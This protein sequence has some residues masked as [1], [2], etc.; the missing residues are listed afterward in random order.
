MRSQDRRLLAGEVTRRLVGAFFETYNEIGFG[1]SEA[2]CA[3]SLAIVLEDHGIEFQ[4]EPRIDVSF[5]G[6]R[7]GTTR[8]DFVVEGVVVLELKALRTLEP[9]HSAQMLNYLRAT[10]IEVGLLL[11]FGREPEFKRSI[12]TND[13]K[14]PVKPAVPP[15]HSGSYSACHRAHP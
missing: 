7:I 10:T 14:P 5:R 4:K 8:P 15:N 12:Y 9:W 13:R 6:R 1:F 3:A 11:N 2:L